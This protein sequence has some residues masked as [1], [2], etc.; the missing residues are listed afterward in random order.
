M[1]QLT[2]Q[3]PLPAPSAIALDLGSNCRRNREQPQTPPDG[4]GYLISASG[5]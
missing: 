1:G 3:V 2:L 4:A 5:S